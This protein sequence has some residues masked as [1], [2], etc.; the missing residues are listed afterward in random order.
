MNTQV[1]MLPTVLIVA[2]EPIFRSGL[3][4]MLGNRCSVVGAVGTVRDAKQVLALAQPR[5]LVL[6]L[7]PPLPDAAPEAVCNRLVADHPGTAALILLRES[8]GELVR[9]ACRCGARGVVDAGLDA[10]HLHA[11]LDQIEAGEMAIHSQLIRHLMALEE[12][13]DHGVQ[14][15]RQMRDRDL[16]I[17][18][19][20]A[21]GQTGQEI[22]RGLGCSAKAID[23]TIERVSHRLGAAHRAH[24]VAI[25]MRNGWI[26]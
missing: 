18:Q 25:T 23:L 8:Q 2:T 16:Q 12:G 13:S 10:E 22:A 4:T 1:R 5:L 3:V 26:R 21:K 19:A 7:D 17:L 20:L 15:A 9:L 14:G 6:N 24:A 11:I